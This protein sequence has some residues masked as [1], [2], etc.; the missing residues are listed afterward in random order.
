MYTVSLGTEHGQAGQPEDR[1]EEQQ[2]VTGCVKRGCRDLYST[3]E[4]ADER[5]SY[6]EQENEAAGQLRSMGKRK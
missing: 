5:H 6:K 3:V 4:T 1:D 2:K